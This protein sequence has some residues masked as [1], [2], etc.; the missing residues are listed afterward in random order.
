VPKES[1]LAHFQVLLPKK[2][3]SKNVKPMCVHMAGT[4]DQVI[5]LL[6]NIKKIN[7]QIGYL[8]NK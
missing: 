2:W 3:P 5:A 4:G 1:H 6:K 8:G 7:F